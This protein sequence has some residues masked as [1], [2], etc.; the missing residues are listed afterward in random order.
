MKY[1][2]IDPYYNSHPLILPVKSIEI[3]ER[4]WFYAFLTTPAPSAFWW[5]TMKFSKR[6]SEIPKGHA[7]QSQKLFHN[8]HLGNK[9]ESEERQARGC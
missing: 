2:V 9:E 7:L 4:T 1:L 3:S 8:F 5:E 6:N